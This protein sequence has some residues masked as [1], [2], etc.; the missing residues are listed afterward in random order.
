[1]GIRLD[2][3]QRVFPVQKVYY[4]AKYDETWGE[5]EVD[6]V[7]FAKLPFRYENKPEVRFNKNEVKA[8]HWIE[9]GKIHAF[10]KEREEKGEKTTP[11]MKK[12]LDYKL[13]QWWE[14]FETG[15][16]KGDLKQTVDL[17]V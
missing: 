12:I 3:P 6:Y 4:Q 13:M 8:V 1:M 5:N 17:M 15:A 9:R 14:A 10:L 11:W 16:L 7:L 2:H